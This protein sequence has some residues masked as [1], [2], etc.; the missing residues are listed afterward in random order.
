MPCSLKNI[1]GQLKGKQA[2]TRRIGVG[3]ERA[4]QVR[5]AGIESHSRGDRLGFPLL[6]GPGVRGLDARGRG[7]V[8]AGWTAGGWGRS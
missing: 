7:I 6:L 3:R 2:P 4:P 5:L 8:G 1:P